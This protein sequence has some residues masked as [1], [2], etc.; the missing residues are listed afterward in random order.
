MPSLVDVTDPAIKYVNSF[1]VGQRRP[2][3]LASIPCPS[4]SKSKPYMKSQQ[5]D[6][7]SLRRTAASSQRLSMTETSAS[8]SDNARFPEDL[9]IQIAA[10]DKLENGKGLVF[11]DTN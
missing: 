7:Q 2:S 8:A 6:G 5:A 11:L 1:F 3:V 4:V 10:L 9:Q